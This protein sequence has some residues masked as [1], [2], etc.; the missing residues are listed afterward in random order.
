MSQLKLQLPVGTWDYLPQEAYAKRTIEEK[1]LRVFYENGYEYLQTPSFENFDVF[2]HDA[3]AYVQENM[4]K[5]FDQK[6]RILALRPDSTGSIARVAATKLLEGQDFLRLCYVQNAFGFLGNDSSEKNEYTQAGV[7]FLGE[8]S[9]AA[10]AEVIS[11]SIQALLEIGLSDFKIDIG[12]VAYFKGLLEGSDISEQA[13]EKI[14]G[15][16]DTKN[17]IELE[18]ELERLG[19][20]QQT[21]EALLELC[22]LFGGEEVLERAKQFAGNETC[23]RAVQN[24]EDVY[25][26]LCDLGFAQY[27][28]IDFGILNNFSY[29]SGILFRGIVDGLGRPILSGGRYDKL[30][31]EFGVDCPATGFAMGVKELLVVLEKQNKLPRD[32]KKITVLRCSESTRSAAAKV[33]QQLRAAGNRVILTERRDNYIAPE[34]ECVDFNAQLQ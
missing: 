24:M 3:V 6:G 14:R 34:Y 5:F 7:E 29:Y 31:N 26:I 8:S 12:Q 10:D 9:P 32:D 17:N 23:A 11:L 18:Y 16:V 27:L 33:A 19:V 15:L 30:L 25:R 4:I 28:S 1:I 22:D 20:P 2:T 21:K 13:I